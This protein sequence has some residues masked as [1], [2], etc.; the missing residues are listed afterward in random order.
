VAR[1]KSVARYS[2]YLLGS[3]LLSRLLF[4]LFS[5][6]AA[7]QLGPSLF[8]A[9]AFSLVVVELAN[10]FG[11]LG[12]TR[13]GTRELVRNWDDRGSIAG[14]VMALQVSTS[15]LFSMIILLALVSFAPD[16]PRYELLLIGLAAILVSGAISAT[17]SILIANESFFLSATAS[18]LGRVVFVGAGFAAISAGVSVVYVMWGFLAGLII[19]VALRIAW[20][21]K[22]ILRFSFR[23]QLAQLW[24][25]L[26]ASVPFALGATAS[27]VLLQIGT[28]LLGII[29]DDA[30]VGVYGV[31]FAL[32][33]P[34]M[35][36]PIVLAKT[37]FPGLTGM[38]AKDENAARM[39]S[40][41][42]F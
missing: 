39:N 2:S 35:W 36:A 12:I 5:L 27:I 30:A 1:F 25:M 23:F 41:H 4:T 31:A 40:W 26:V 7:V 11:D 16:S 33:I 15:F 18:L 22:R 24:Q 3:K 28:V 20:V 8:G 37:I 38:Y 17:E 29:D 9:L 32:F 13:Y 21:M 6:Y 42:R 14:K 34:F 10:S 19:E